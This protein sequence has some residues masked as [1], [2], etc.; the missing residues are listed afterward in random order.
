MN[1]LRMRI[2]WNLIEPNAPTKVGATWVHTYDASELIDLKTQIGYAAANGE[3]VLIE[4]TQGTD[5]PFWLYQAPNNSHGKNYVDLTA[6][7]TDFWS[8]PLMQTFLTDEMKY[9]AGQLAGTPG[10]VGYEPIDEPDPG[11][12][13]ISHATT[14]LLLDKQR[15]IAQQ[16]RSADPARVQFFT[17]HDSL[18]AGLANADLSGWAAMGNVAFDVHDYFGGR[19]GVGIITDPANPAVGEATQSLLDFTLTAETPPYLGTT[20]VQVRFM[21]YFNSFLDPVGIPLFVGEFAGKGEAEPN[22]MALFGTMTQAFNLT[23]VA[24]TAS[25]YN[26]INSVFKSNGTP[27][28]WVAILSSAARYSG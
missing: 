20:D 11:N 6:L 8:D 14:Q 9:L 15:S 2:H 13:T 18:G 17:T 21:N 25:C 3:Y 4:N 22:I 27:E 12:L 28:P 24:W 16:V 5:W 23:G 10:I 19:W 1:F 26:G 7:E